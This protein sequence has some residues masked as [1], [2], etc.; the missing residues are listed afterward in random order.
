MRDRGQLVKIDN[1]IFRI[2]TTILFF[3][4]G[5]SHVSVAF[6]EFRSNVRERIVDARSNERKMRNENRDTF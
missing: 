5:E 3:L 6:E 4:P 2:V 1:W